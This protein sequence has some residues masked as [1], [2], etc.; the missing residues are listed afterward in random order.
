MGYQ[1]IESRLW[2]DPFAA[3]DKLSTDDQEQRTRGGLTNLAEI[4]T[5]G[6]ATGRSNVLL[7]CAMVSGQPYAEDKESRIRARYA[8]GSALG[9]GGYKPAASD[10][11]GLVA[12][13]WPDSRE[14]D[15]WIKNTNAVLR[16]GSGIGQETNFCRESTNLQL[17][18]PFEEYEPREY[19][20]V[21]EFSEL[22][23]TQHYQKILLVWLDEE[24]FD[25]DPAPRLALFYGAINN[26]LPTNIS[27]AMTVSRAIIGPRSSSTLRALLASKTDLGTNANLW[28]KICETLKPIQ[29]IL[30]TPTAM[31]EVLV[32][33]ANNVTND[34]RVPRTAVAA[35]L[36]DQGLFASV[37]NFACTDQQ[38]AVEAL[39]ELKL[40]GIDLITQPKQHLVLISE[41]DSFF[42]RM[43]GLAFAAEMS[44]RQTNGA[45]HP[46]NRLDF[47]AQVR[48]G[49]NLWSSN[50]HRF[51]YL[52]GLDGEAAES[53]DEGDRRSE[54]EQ[55][56]RDRPST[57]EEIRNWT[58]DANKAEGSAQFD[59]L[60][61]LGDNIAELDRA[62][63]RQQGGRVAAVG[64]N[65]SDV[66]DTLLIL[67]ALRQRLPD[68]VFFTSELDAR[69]WDPKELRW[70]RNL[71]VVSGYGLQLS[72]HL[73]A[74]SAPFRESAQCAH[75]MATLCALRDQRLLSLDRVPPR[76]FEIGRHDQMGDALS[77]SHS[78]PRILA[79]QRRP[80]TSSS[81]WTSFEG[82]T[83]WRIGY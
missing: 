69:Y 7:L 70:S 13:D 46:T 23:T 66:Y 16:V 75:F 55:K 21:H 20:S 44:V 33:R 27:N 32:G 47:I 67:Q 82:R 31:D 10:H 1:N 24:Y 78:R 68:A 52:Q 58:P 64:I 74:G 83:I 11:I 43:S 18:V 81:D 39:D 63:W 6:L 72:N 3:W 28:F 53:A 40:R 8:I 36:R 71:V 41:W 80:S 15:R 57:I 4:L 30:A 26:L 76:R 62:L 54:K 65:G 12:N 51:V 50:L 38:L 48:A 73:Q 79:E 14:L 61:R 17:R 25:D 5:N 45:N 2:E 49:S 22:Q 34:F 37:A 29:L 42:A 19:L 35:A 77:P 56:G 59:Y 60:G 9:S